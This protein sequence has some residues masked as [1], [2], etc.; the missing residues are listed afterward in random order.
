MAIEQYPKAMY[1]PN[2]ETQ[3]AQDQASEQ[4]LRDQGFVDGV[5]W[6]KKLQ[7]QA[8][9]PATNSTDAMQQSGGTTKPA[10][11]QPA[12]NQPKKSA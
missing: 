6:T 9:K 4:N 10:G 2:G 1:G 12:Q 5:E 7:D 8:N 3:T 11:N